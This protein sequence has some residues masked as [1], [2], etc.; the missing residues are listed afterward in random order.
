MWFHCLPAMT[1]TLSIKNV[2]DGV[3]E[4]LRQRAERNRRS[5]QK[6]L[7]ALVEQAVAP[8]GAVLAREPEGRYAV[9][10]APAGGDDLL[11]ELDSIVAG[12]RWGQAPFLSREQLHDRALAREIDFEARSAESK[13]GPR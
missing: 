10:E 3:A 12:S 1:V 5:L 11:C 9:P 4:R 7:L 8:V 6:E 13:A 2:P